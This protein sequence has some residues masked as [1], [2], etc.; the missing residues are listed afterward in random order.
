MNRCF[1]LSLFAGTVTLL[2]GQ[3]VDIAKFFA[4]NFIVDGLNNFYVANH[5]SEIDAH[6]FPGKGSN[7]DFATMKKLT[8][9]NAAPMTVS[10][11]ASMESQVKRAESG[12][13][14]NFRVVRSFSDLRKCKE[15]GCYGVMFYRQRPWPIGGD[16][17]ILEDWKKK[18]LIVF[19][20]AY[21][22]S[23][24]SPPRRGNGER[25]Q[26]GRRVDSTWQTS[27]CRIE[28]VEYARR[29]FPL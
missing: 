7:P 16:L 12:Y 14:K 3:S 6:P 25:L 4:E 26:R 15:D 29:Y 24:P 2:H 19:Q 1:F 28:S 11:L 23:H 27:H 10:S 13:Y 9:R 22:S 17:S 8:G 5:P 20:I 21:G 18:G